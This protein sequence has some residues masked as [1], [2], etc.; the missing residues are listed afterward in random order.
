MRLEAWA[1]NMEV[2]ATNIGPSHSRKVLGVLE[3]TLRVCARSVETSGR[4]GGFDPRKAISSCSALRS[5]L[6]KCV[7]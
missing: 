3:V 2:R 7:E 1:P 4:A 6:Y 5:N